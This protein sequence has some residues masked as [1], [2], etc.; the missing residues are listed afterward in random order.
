[1]KESNRK[2]IILYSSIIFLCTSLIAI[3]FGDQYY[4]KNNVYAVNQTV[5]NINNSTA[6]TNHLVVSANNNTNN[7]S[8][9]L[10]L[11]E[12][13]T[14]L[15]SSN[16][17]Q[18]IAT[19]AYVWGYPLVTMERSFNYFT[20]PN[21]PP[22]VGHGHANTI[23]FARELINASFTDVVSPNVD[24]LYGISWLN[25]KKEPLVLT[26]PPITHRYYTFEFLD[27]Y[28]NVFTYVGSRATGSNGGIY[29]ITSP[30]WNGQVPS[31]M[32]E[33]KSPTNL[34]WILNRILVNGPL[35]VPNV[36]AIQDQIGLVPLSALQGKSDLQPTPSSNI[37]K[38]IPIKPQPALI[39]SSGIKVYDEISQGLVN[40]S[41]NPP[42]PQLL[43]KFDSIGIG[44]G[45]IPSKDATNNETIKKALE[46]GITEGEKLID[47]KV[48]NAGTKM[49]GW[50][51]NTHLG[52]YGT[53]YL[54]RAAATKIGFGANMPEESLYPLTFTDINGNPLNGSHNY[55]I[56]FKPGQTP[57]VKAFWSI[58]MYN[59]KSYFIEN[60][61]NRYNIGGLTQGLKNNTDGSIDI[62]L[63]NQNP[64]K[65]K[66]SNWLPS[67]KDSFNLILRM[68]VPQ[69]QVL[70][71]VWSYPIIERIG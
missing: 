22:A 12:K 11:N 17:P 3:S 48:A 62:Y 14:Q 16:N 46:M 10:A 54:L 57:P 51:V 71:G 66:V 24:T 69:E 5:N 49:N 43:A 60:P 47:A 31:G 34:A 63:Q 29:L 52:N 25:L 7:N 65:D 42:D 28:T 21:S 8:D 38:E 55:I 67:P 13:M 36:H 56:H 26:V 9:I 6:N 68:Y 23:S 20:S 39:P 15:L 2:F 61:I 30:D 59:N 19:L 33:I 1:V 27:A 4:I 44:P 70:N 32:T 40:N 41:P 35:D 58:T 37:S 18:D 45:K 50:I 53:D 64:G